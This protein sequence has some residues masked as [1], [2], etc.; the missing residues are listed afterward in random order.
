MQKLS[1]ILLEFI[2]LLMLGSCIGT[3]SG[4]QTNPKITDTSTATIYPPI[5][6]R[7]VSPIETQLIQQSTRTKL[8]V[9]TDVPTYTP[10]PTSTAIPTLQ[11][12]E[13]TAEILGLLSIQ[14]NDCS[15]PC[16][17]NFVPGKTRIGDM[18]N[19]LNRY[20]AMSVGT[21]IFHDKGGLIWL[22]FQIKQ[23]L[24]LSTTLEF[25]GDAG[26]LTWQQV[27]VQLMRQ[28]E[29]TDGTTYEI[30]WGDSNL[31]EMTK[32]YNIAQIFSTYGKPTEVLIF[33]NQAALLNEP[34]PISLVVFYQ[35]DG[36]MI[37]YV[38]DDMPVTTYPGVMWC[39]SLAFPYF[40]FW[41]P[42]K[43]TTIDDV[44]SWISGYQF[45][46]RLLESGKA[47]TLEEA[48]GM[49]IDELVLLYDTDENACVTTPREIWPW[50][51]E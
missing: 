17:W 2:V 9:P 3:P 39:P 42:S 15:F 12:Q 1:A 14:A 41:S 16:W 6:T 47:K 28:V 35:E 19:Y 34:W 38:A 8:T 5:I 7:A 23:N 13:A 40:W 26:I 10:L 21:P 27:Q 44:L 25:K 30:S 4:I 43:Y 45:N 22:R 46:N 37:E 18:Q 36:F 29:F 24:Y 50:P 32:S 20:N 48:T 51:G 11:F 31:A 33:T 49:S